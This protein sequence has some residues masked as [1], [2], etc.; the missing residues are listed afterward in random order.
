M[1][2]IN[3]TLIAL[4]A[5]LAVGCS[6]WAKKSTALLLG[7]QVSVFMESGVVPINRKLIY[8]IVKSLDVQGYDPE[9]ASADE[10]DEYFDLVKRELRHEYDREWRVA[11]SYC[12][13]AYEEEFARAQRRLATL[14]PAETAGKVRD[15]CLFHR[16]WE[17]GSQRIFD[18]IFD[19]AWKRKIRAKGG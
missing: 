7:K 18:E 10:G 12:D 8:D 11:E 3:F 13:I 17:A 1:R 6:S 16:G 15:A 4:T 5:A 19:L 2:K 9:N 14:L